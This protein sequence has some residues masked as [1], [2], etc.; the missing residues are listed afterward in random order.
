M[1]STS[2][3]GLLEAV[4]GE[5]ECQS[6]RAALGE[7]P[8][9]VTVVA[10][11]RAAGPCWVIVNSFTSLSLTP[12]LV[13]VCLRAHF[14]P[15]A[16]VAR[17]R[18]FTVDVIRGHREELGRRFAS[19]SRR[20][21]HARFAGVAHRPRRRVRRSRRPRLLAR[22]PVSTRLTRRRPHD[23]DRRSDC[24]LCSAVRGRSCFT[25]GGTANSYWPH[26][27][28]GSPLS[29]CNSDLYERR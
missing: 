1:E 26:P 22:L 16:I 6:L 15:G 20:W 24:A 5:A 21:G 3:T 8:T 4:P 19:V 14:S 12:R 13:V 7:F 23:R 18:V 9:G 17:N 28:A 11:A 25:P 10:S 29:C 27:W 2:A